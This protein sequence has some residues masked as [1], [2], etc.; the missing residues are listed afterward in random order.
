MEEKIKC[1]VWDLDNTLWSGVLQ[2]ADN[3]VLD[4]KTQIVIREFDKRGILQ[5]IASKNNYGDVI[6]KLREL[7]ILD[8]FLYPKICW[9][10]KSE[11]IR[12]IQQELN[13]GI[14]SIAF[15]DDQDYELE[16]VH[17]HLP[18]VR[19]IKADRIP[20]LLDY[21]EFNPKYLTL[22]SKNRRSMYLSEAVRRKEEENFNG[23]STDFLKYLNMKIHIDYAIEEDLMRVEE[24]TVRTHQLNSTGCIYS[25]DDLKKLIKNDKYDLLIV[26]L[27]DRFGSYGKIGIVLLER[28]SRSIRIKL[29]L[30]S[31]R[32]MSRGIGSVLVNFIKKKALVEKKELFAEFIETEK[33]RMMKLML[34]LN[35]FEEINDKNYLLCKNLKNNEIP[36][37][38]F[39][40]SKN[41]KIEG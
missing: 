20:E 3:V 4:E 34:M 11:S 7:N 8:Y 27:E 40:D 35:D 28:D 38:I 21:P 36:D 31:C 32:V 9:D 30:L 15:I 14:E 16:E 24:L 10:N 5:S 22:D 29:L 25:Y 1:V 2:E 13:I 39:V 23:S 37:Y 12:K 26:G 18:E 17:Y 6:N 19:C 41:I 33:N